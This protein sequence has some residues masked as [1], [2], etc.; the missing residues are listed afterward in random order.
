MR[1]RQG[2]SKSTIRGSEPASTRGRGRGGRYPRP[3]YRAV[4]SSS[5]EGGV[6]SPLHTATEEEEDSDAPSDE[7]ITQQ[8]DQRIRR[9]APRVMEEK[10]GWD[11]GSDF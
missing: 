10:I 6:T 4:D 3:S 11:D 1:N 9:P 2:K 8:L 5:D 7:S